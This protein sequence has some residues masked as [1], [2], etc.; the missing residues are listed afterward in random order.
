MSLSEKEIQKLDEHI[1]KIRAG[2]CGV[3]KLRL[4]IKEVYDEINEMRSKNEIY[5]ITEEIGAAQKRL[6]ALW[7]K[8]SKLEA[9]MYAA[10]RDLNILIDYTI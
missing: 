9:E 10:R 7:T 3:L 8:K 5:I 1:T 4:Q 2:L 6:D